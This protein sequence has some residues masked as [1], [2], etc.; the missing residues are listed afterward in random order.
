MLRRLSN[1]GGG[2]PRRRRETGRERA[3]G[4]SVTRAAGPEQCWPGTL[5]PGGDVTVYFLSRVCRSPRYVIPFRAG[6]LSGRLYPAGQRR[7]RLQPCR[8]GRSEPARHCR[9]RAYRRASGSAEGRR[10]LR[11]ARRGWRSAAAGRAVPGG[12]AVEA[13]SVRRPIGG[14]TGG[15]F[16]HPLLRRGFADA[17]LLGAAS[18]TICATARRSAPGSVGRRPVAAGHHSQRVLAG[19]TALPPQIGRGA[20]ATTSRTRERRRRSPASSPA[21]KQW[22]PSSTWHAPTPVMPPRPTIGTP[23]RGC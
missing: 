2:A 12:A 7:G 14:E 11:L 1:R 16:P 23:I 18:P 20:C 17:R 8:K 9:Q 22:P 15:R 4:S 19:P 3:P 6:M 13:G 5:Y 21:P 10:C